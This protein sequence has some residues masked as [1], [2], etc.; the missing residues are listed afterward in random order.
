[1]SLAGPSHCCL[2]LQLCMDLDKM[3]ATFLVSLLF[4]CSIIVLVH[5]P[6]CPFFLCC[7]HAMVFAAAFALFDGGFIFRVV[8]LDFI[9]QNLSS[10]SL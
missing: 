9:A 1:M 7:G 6:I 5:Q 4:D 10:F 3:Y 2:T 8:L